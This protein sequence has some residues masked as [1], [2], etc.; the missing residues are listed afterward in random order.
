[1]AADRTIRRR[2]RALPALLTAIVV[3]GC[4]APTAT[5]PESDIDVTGLTGGLV[6]HWKPGATINIFPDTTGLSSGVFNIT[7]AVE[8]AARAWREES[9]Y[10]EVDLRLVSSP[11][12]ADIIIHRKSAPRLVETVVNG[13][14]CDLRPIA[15]AGYTL[16]C[17]DVGDAPVLPLKGGGPVGRVKMDIF[18]DPDRVFGGPDIN[19]FQAFDALVAHEIGHALGIGGHSQHPHD[20]MHPFPRVTRPS[21]NDAA[22]LREVLYRKADIRF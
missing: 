20:L 16:F 18:V 8:R 7:S 10:G 11:S 19:I 15:V 3:A 9:F 21:F 5:P 1:M 12:D 22:A 6:Y 2:G 17:P 14:D 4:D 13:G